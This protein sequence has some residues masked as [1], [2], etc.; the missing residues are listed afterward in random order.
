M[1]KKAPG[2]VELDEAKLRQQ[3]LGIKLRQI[4]DAVVNEPVPEHLLDI[5][6]RADDGKPGDE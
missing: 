6:R 1:T 2:A 4:F 5:L 3:A